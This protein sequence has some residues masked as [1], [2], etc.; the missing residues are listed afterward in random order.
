MNHNFQAF[1]FLI[2]PDKHI[3]SK[4]VFFFWLVFFVERI[5]GLFHK[6]ISFLGTKFFIDVYTIYFPFFPVMIFIF[7]FTA[8][9]FFCLVLYFAFIFDENVHYLCALGLFTQFT[10]LSLSGLIWIESSMCFLCKLT[11]RRKN[12]IKC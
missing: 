1:H 11:N 2:S 7:T 10:I 9:I 4:F 8:I 5:K 3:T 12:E 6:A